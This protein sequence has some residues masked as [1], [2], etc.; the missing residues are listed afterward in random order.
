VETVLDDDFSTN[1]AGEG[2]PAGWTLYRQ[3]PTLGKIMIRENGSAKELY[4]KDVCDKSEIGI[5]RIISAVP[6]K[7]YRLTAEVR[8]VG[9]NFGKSAPSLQ[10][11]F[12][13]RPKHQV[14]NFWMVSGKPTVVTGQANADK[15]QIYLFTLK[16]GQPEFTVGRIKLEV[17]DTPF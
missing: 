9:G 14:N 13:S 16:Y 10:L 11:R 8:A 15:L 17:S 1:A 3:G 4:M 6:G 12:L 2:V 7:Y 5:T